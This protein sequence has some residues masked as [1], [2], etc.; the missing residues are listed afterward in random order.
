M[1]GTQEMRAMRARKPKTTPVATAGMLMSVIFDN[2]V[3][4][5]PC[6]VGERSMMVVEGKEG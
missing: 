4:F 5:T 3:L 2:G 1:G 6:D